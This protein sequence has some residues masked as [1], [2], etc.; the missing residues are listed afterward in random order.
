MSG[1]IDETP[2][3]SGFATQG[4]AWQEGYEW[5]YFRGDH[6][7]KDIFEAIEACGYDLDSAEADEFE[8]GADFAQLEQSGN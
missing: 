5:A 1:S 2:R 4:K 7:G 3:W 6:G 8:K